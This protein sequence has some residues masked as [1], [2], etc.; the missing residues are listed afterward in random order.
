MSYVTAEELAAEWGDAKALQLS[1]TTNK[2]EI[3]YDKI[4]LAIKGAEDEINAYCS[5][6]YITPFNPAPYMIIQYTKRLTMIC[7][8]RDKGQYGDTEKNEYEDIMRE[9]REI[10][11]GG[12]NIPDV[13]TIKQPLN[14]NELPKFNTS[15]RNFSREKLRDF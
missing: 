2:G 3:D 4:A 1:S 13:D 7:M 11:K 12:K 9:L 6:R 14:K 15:A 5:K 8:L 10:A